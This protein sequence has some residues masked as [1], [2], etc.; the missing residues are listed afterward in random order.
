RI[1]WIVRWP[2]KVKPGSTCATPVISMD[3]YPT[4]LDVAGLPP[5]PDHPVDGK[6]LL[7]LFEQSGRLDRDAVYLH[8][9]NYAFHK[10][11]R[12]GGVIREGEYKLIKRYRDGEL[13][14][15]HLNSDIGEKKNLA[16]QSPELAGF[17][18]RKLEA[19]LRETGAKM[20]VRSAP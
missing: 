16:A 19:W 9:P 3:C 12:L 20:P 7:P 14:L 17:M 15:Y 10:K 18:E 8:Y 4:L 6:S 13:E 1:P 11:N 2:G 5:T